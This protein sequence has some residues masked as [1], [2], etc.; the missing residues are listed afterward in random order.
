MMRRTLIG[1]AL[2]L[3][4]AG[5][6]KAETN[7]VVYRAFYLVNEFPRRGDVLAYD[8]RAH[9]LRFNGYFI[10]KSDYDTSG[11][12]APARIITFK[13]PHKFHHAKYDAEQQKWVIDYD[14]KPTKNLM[15]YPLDWE[16]PDGGRTTSVMENYCLRGGATGVGEPYSVYGGTWPEVIVE[17]TDEPNTVFMMADYF[18]NPD[19]ADRTGSANEIKGYSEVLTGLIRRNGKMPMLTGHMSYVGTER[20][21]KSIIAQLRPA[22]KMTELVANDETMKEA[23]DNVVN[24]LSN[25]KYAA[26]W[27]E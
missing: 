6:A 18:R 8:K 23:V 22:Q 5:I 20:S 11:D 24:Y 15:I 17:K 9:L 26:T 4:A 25:K 13:A 7:Y 27:V 14:R 21:G 12:N 2:S 3:I 19:A 16:W 1:V 10:F